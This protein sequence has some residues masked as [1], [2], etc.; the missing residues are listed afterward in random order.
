[1]KKLMQKLINLILID[2][3]IILYTNERIASEALQV[4]GVQTAILNF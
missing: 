3:K 1:M 2:M 4:F